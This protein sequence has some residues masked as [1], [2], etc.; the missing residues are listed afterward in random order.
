M[1][2][3]NDTV[4]YE[5][6]NFCLISV[7]TS[8]DSAKFVEQWSRIKAFVDERP[9]RTFLICGDFNA[10]PHQ[11]TRMSFYFVDKEEE[12]NL[13]IDLNFNRY[14]IVNILQSSG[15]MRC[16]TTQL[17]KMFLPAFFSIDGFVCISPVG[18]KAPNMID[19]KC[20]YITDGESLVSK[21]DFIYPPLEWPSDH[22]MVI[23]EFPF[24]KVCSM[25]AF[26]ESISTTTPLN[27]FEIFTKRALDLYNSSS[28]IRADFKR[29]KTEIMNSDYT[30][31]GETVPRKVSDLVK[32]KHISKVT[33][34]YAVCGSVFKPPRHFDSLPHSELY[35]TLSHEYSSQLHKCF[36]ELNA[37]KAT[38]DEKELNKVLETE[39]AVEFVIDM[40]ERF[41][42]SP[43]LEPFFNEWFEE[44]QS[45]RK[46]T[47]HDVLRNVIYAESPNFICLQEVSRGMMVSFDKLKD[48]YNSWGYDLLK[49]DIG[50]TKTV[51]LML[52][53]RNEEEEDDY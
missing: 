37:K 41:M 49:S 36:D 38:N 4:I 6:E 31:V 42:Q 10:T 17:K 19:S 33:R 22:G 9:D 5:A 47:I 45:T 46:M 51:G 26:G 2:F 43:I 18:A 52:I 16:L 14:A 39:H 53:R 34:D 1:E 35:E 13:L 20:A 24:G 28:E 25:N 21:T 27:V 29:I 11:K 23:T 48:L 32:S 8:N 44:L 50:G 40:Y 7:H 3:G 15:K 30:I 12:D